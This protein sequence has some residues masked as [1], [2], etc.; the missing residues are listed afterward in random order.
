MFRIRLIW[1]ISV[2]IFCAALVGCRGTA[3]L[4]SQ[5]GNGGNSSVVLAMTDSP[6]SL[7]SILSAQVT[8]TGA[9]LTPGNVSLFSGPTTV[10]L[11]RLQT[12]IAYLT[13]A[14]NIPAG[15]YTG[16]T[17]TFA[18]PMLTIENDTG[19]AIVSGTVT[20]NIG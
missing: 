2:L 9:T 6:P 4:G 3:Q 8:L 20:C 1:P 16:L 7:V 19:A 10:E 11:T 17:L 5:G 12:D 15:P 13:T 18:N 14:A